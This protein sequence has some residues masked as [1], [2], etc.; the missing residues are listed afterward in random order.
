MRSSGSQYAAAGTDPRWPPLLKSRHMSARA[1]KNGGRLVAGKYRFIA[2]SAK[3][4]LGHGG[5]L[6]L[7]AVNP[8][9]CFGSSRALGLLLSRALSS[10]LRRSILRMGEN[11]SSISL[12]RKQIVDRDVLSHETH[13]AVESVGGL[14]RCEPLEAAVADAIVLPEIA[15]HSFETV[16]RLA[17]DYLRAPSA[18]VA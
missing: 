9:P 3:T 12:L 15:V 1:G 8:R 11:T 5:G 13:A 6:P 10:R 7:D 4:W 18:G 14:L 2:L 16:V 17:S